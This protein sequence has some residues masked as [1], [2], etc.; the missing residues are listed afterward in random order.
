M[1]CFPRAFLKKMEILGDFVS[2]GSKGDWWE[3]AVVVE[4]K[5]LQFKN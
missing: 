3:F 4:K 1:H 2:G 5:R